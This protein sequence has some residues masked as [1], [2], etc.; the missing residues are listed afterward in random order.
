M[1]SNSCIF[2]LIILCVI[3]RLIKI[4]F[5]LIEIEKGGK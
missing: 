4:L 5:S 2:L 3:R 1:E